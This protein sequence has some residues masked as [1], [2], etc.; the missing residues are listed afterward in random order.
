MGTQRTGV[1]APIGFRA[2][3]IACGLKAKGALDLALV[4]SDR[5]AVAA[6]LL[7]T[8]LVCGAPVIV[9]RRHLASGRARAIVANAGNSNACT[10]ARGEADA[11]AMCRA[12]GDA[13]GIPAEEVLVASTGVIGRPLP[14]GKVLPGI[15]RAAAALSPDGNESAARAIMTTDTLLKEVTARVDVGGHT[16]TI[17]GIAKGAGMIAPKLATMLAFFTTDAEI[18]APV[19]RQ[20]LVEAAAASFNRVTVDGDTSTS[21]M[22]LVLANGAAGAGPIEP[23]TPAYE[24]F[25]AALREACVD[26]AK[27]V[28]RDGEGATTFVTVHVSGAPSDADAD[29]A[30]R[31]VAES[32]LVKTAIFGGDPNWG[33]I[34]AA[35][36]RSGVA[37]DPNRLRIWVDDLLLFENG[38]PADFSLRDAE[39]HFR[40]KVLTIRAD[41]GAGAGAAEV[42]T[43]DLSY[44]YVKI[45]AEY[46]T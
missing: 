11:L 5:P 39:R 18:A 12:V 7:T 40:E 27:M 2:T 28:A 23:G 31:T 20:L 36:G 1:C 26:L 4:A 3:G 42:Y 46:T 43:C 10:G 14:V 22:L 41:L 9:T 38:M 33:R 8:N 13:L 17:G 25:G 30:A 35:L 16:V 45:N 21:D 24:S 44:D 37:F 34:A 15:A 32:P 6:G 29:R 19:L